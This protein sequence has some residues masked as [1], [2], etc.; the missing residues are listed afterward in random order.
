[1]KSDKLTVLQLINVRWYNASAEYAIQISKY[2]KNRGHNILIMCKEGIPAV[3]HAIESGLEV[4]TT[5]SFRPMN[6]LTDLK[7]LK[8]ISKNLNPDIIHAHHADGHALAV[9][10]KK[11]FEGPKIIRT[12]VDIRS[13]KKNFFNRFIH[14]NTDRII[15]PGEL[16]KRKVVN[17]TG[18][19]FEKVKVVYGGVDLKRF[20]GNGGLEF[21]KTFGISED[22][23]VVGLLARLDP[24]K[25]HLFFIRVARELKK[26]FPH[27]KFIVAGK[28]AEYKKENLIQ[29][30]KREGL[31]KDIIYA[32]FVDNVVSA[33]KAFDICVLPSFGSEAHP[34]VLFEYMACG[35]PV[36]ASRVGIVGEIVDDGINGLIAEPADIKSFVD[37]IKL[38]VNSPGKRT[39]L[40]LEARKKIERHFT[41]DKFVRDVEKIYLELKMHENRA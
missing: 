32:G 19:D 10:L 35:K 30:S 8:N 7:K 24:I 28:D 21:R 41:I 37:K 13:P 22:T 25:G 17:S 36:V 3:N 18:I 16:L 11:F 23:T 2:L 20:N 39:E 26:I 34:R 5:L 15:V 38:L 31:D 27:L 33:I 6:F 12:R 4:D 29:I 9:V 14:K 1:M 40:G